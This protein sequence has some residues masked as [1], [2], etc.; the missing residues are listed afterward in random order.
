MTLAA[1]QQKET[2]YQEEQTKITN[3]ER[4]QIWDIHHLSTRFYYTFVYCLS[5]L[6]IYIYIFTIINSSQNKGSNHFPFQFL[7]KN[8]TINT[9]KY[10]SQLLILEYLI[11][12]CI[13]WEV[14]I[15]ATNFFTIRI[16]SYQYFTDK[17]FKTLKF[18]ASQ[19][20]TTP[21]PKSFTALPVSNWRKPDDHFN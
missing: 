17:S 11:R 1:L 6:F 16:F 2:L 3:R 13:H 10:P 18:S 19:L 14:R 7:E 21:V 20:V 4:I 8:R 12:M 15:S 5:Y 9:K